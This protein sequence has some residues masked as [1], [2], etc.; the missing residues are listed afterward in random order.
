MVVN[1]GDAGA[2]MVFNDDSICVKEIAAGATVETVESR[3]RSSRPS[4][5]KRGFSAA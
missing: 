1:V 2:S 3:Q 4:R 5:L